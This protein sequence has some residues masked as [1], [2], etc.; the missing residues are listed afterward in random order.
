[1]NTNPIAKAL[2]EAE[3]LC[4]RL[5]RNFYGKPEF[6]TVDDLQNLKAAIDKLKGVEKEWANHYTEKRGALTARDFGFGDT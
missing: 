6:P 3:R 1:M 2:E 5:H 4:D